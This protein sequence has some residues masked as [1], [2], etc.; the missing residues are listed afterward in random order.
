MGVSIDKSAWG[1]DAHRVMSFLGMD[2]P[3]Q[4]RLRSLVSRGFTPRRVTY[5]GND[6]HDYQ[7]VA[8]HSGKCVDVSG[9][10]TAARG[11]VI[12]W[13]CKPVTQNSP[14]NQTWRLWGRGPA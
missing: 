6:A 2:P 5:G 9:V 12:Q 8:R 1:P 11:A 10:S 13:T 4:K 14:L 3:R 7:L